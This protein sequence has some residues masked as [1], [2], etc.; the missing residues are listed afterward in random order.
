MLCFFLSK[1]FEEQGGRLYYIGSLYHKR[2]DLDGLS[3]FLPAWA[4][5]LFY[6]EL[7]LVICVFIHSELKPLKTK[8]SPQILYI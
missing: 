7:R 4:V 6:D 2:L 1:V 8:Q 3:R 5:L